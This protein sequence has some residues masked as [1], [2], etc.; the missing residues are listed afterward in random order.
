MNT[1]K[2]VQVPVSL[3]RMDLPVVDPKTGMISQE[4]Y[5]F[6]ESM[7]D[8]TGGDEDAVDGAAVT[9]NDAASSAQEANDDIADL[10]ENAVV[11]GRGLEGGGQIG[12]GVRLDAKTDA[13]WVASTGTA[14]KTTPFA[15]PA[16]ITGAV[17]YTPSQITALSSDLTALGKRYRAMEDALLKTEALTP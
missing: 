6:F 7:R 1:F 12:D 8:R 5:T 14:D 2:S 10:R 15:V 16:P 9:A 4:W 11:A 3:P 17:A 13:G